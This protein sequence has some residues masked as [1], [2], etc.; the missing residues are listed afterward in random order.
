MAGLQNIARLLNQ[1]DDG[2][3]PI[4]TGMENMTWHDSLEKIFSDL[5][6]EA[7]INASLHQKSFKHY[8]RKSVKFQLPIIILSV[9]SG[10]GNFVSASFPEHQEMMILIIGGVSI[11][12]SVISSIAQF[13]KLSELSE[14]HRI[15]YVSWEKFY[16]NIKYQ[17]MRK[18]KD[19]DNIKEFLSNVFSE[20]QRLKEISPLIPE[21]IACTIK[22]IR[23]KDMYIP[24]ILN[25]FEH[26]KPYD[27]TPSPS[28]SSDE[29]DDDY[30]DEPTP[31]KSM[32]GGWFSS[33][34]KT[35]PDD[36]IRK[37]RKK[38]RKKKKDL[39]LMEQGLSNGV[40]ILDLTN[41]TALE[42]PL[43]NAEEEN[44]EEVEPTVDPTVE[45]EVRKMSVDFTEKLAT[46]EK[47]L[48]EQ[49]TKLKES[50]VEKVSVAVNTEQPKEP[51]NKVQANLMED[52]NSLLDTTV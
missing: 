12:T 45:D 33:K 5:G 1:G 16:S 49:E 41:E 31:T 46:L 9:L 43:V 35:P 48:R 28:S 30:L 18:R 20:Y 50:T 26:V 15:S 3:D 44:T 40:D 19:R 13:L 24:F 22:R 36:L 14:A 52:M 51:E 27:D 47:S 21:E 42:N 8:Y 23:D 37:K 32:F 6:D 38:K 7:Q 2:K 25:K 29:D 34:P 10:S 11:L 4:N 39:D 17:M